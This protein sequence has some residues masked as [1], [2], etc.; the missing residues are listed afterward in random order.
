M[1][2]KNKKNNIS[3][4]VKNKKNYILAVLLL[5]LIMVGTSVSSVLIYR[6]L[7]KKETQKTE[8]SKEKVEELKDLME[9]ENATIE[10]IE[11]AFNEYFPNMDTETTTSFIDSLAY[12][13]HYNLSLIGEL[14]EDELTYIYEACDING[15]YNPELMANQ[16]LKEKLNAIIDYHA[17][18]SLVNGEII[19][20]VDYGYFIDT[21][22]E[23]MAE[24]YKSIFEFYEKEQKESYIDSEKGELICSVV[25]DRI[26]TL[27]ALIT[28]FNNSTLKEVYKS[29]KDFYLREYYGLY[30]T[31]LVYDENMKL[32]DYI[33]ESYKEVA[34]DKESVIKDNTIKLLSAYESSSYTRNAD[35]ESVLLTITNT[36]K[37]EYD[38]TKSEM[39]GQ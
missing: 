1:S 15:I 12:L 24:D 18:V 33:L 37:S 2:S 7:E 19:I 32:K 13:T 6:F 4:V 11:K 23:Y 27:N 3:T 16:S 34:A 29:T 35:V 8:V 10:D 26:S 5:V 38:A 17:I 9:D 21:Y 30:S 39:S 31:D 14:T 20:A 28:K 25:L 36:T 22:G